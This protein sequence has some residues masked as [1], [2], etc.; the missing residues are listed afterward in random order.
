[1]VPVVEERLGLVDE[2]L[3][4]IRNLLADA[5]GAQSCL[6]P[7]V[8][9]GGCDYR[10]HF[11]EEISCHLDTGNVAQCTQGQTN[12]VLVVVVEITARVS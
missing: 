4:Q 5:N 12:D 3:L 8:W 11:G 1:M 7:D 10:L 2:M 9:V 6:P